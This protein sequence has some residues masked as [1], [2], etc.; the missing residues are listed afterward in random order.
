MSFNNS[1]D[2]DDDDYEP[3]LDSDWRGVRDSPRSLPLVPYKNQVGGHASFLRFS[4]KALCKPLNSKE[5]D[6]YEAVETMHPE[7]KSFIATYLGVVNVTYSTVPEDANIFGVAEG[8]PVVILEENKHILLDDHD[9]LDNRSSS[10]CDSV[11]N[12]SLYSRKLQAQVFKDALSP[13]SLRARFAQLRSAIGAMQRRHSFS[14]PA[15]RPACPIPMVDSDPRTLTPTKAKSP[16]SSEQRI[17]DPSTP[18]PPPSVVQETVDELRDHQ[19]QH[20]PTQH[21]KHHPRAEHDSGDGADVLSPIFQLSEEEEDRAP[22]AHPRKANLRP[23]SQGVRL[24]RSPSTPLRPSPAA[25]EHTVDLPPVLLTP[26]TPT[27][28]TA[29]TPVAHGRPPLHPHAH[30]LTAPATLIRTHTAPAGSASVTYNPWSLHLYHNAASKLGGAAAA[31]EA[32][33]GGRRRTDQF[34]L[35]QDLTS[36][37]RFPCILDLKMG[38]RQHGV[39]ASAEKR[40]S[41]EK[42]CEKSTSWTLGVRIC[43]MQVYKENT[44]AFTYLDKYVGRQINVANF[45]QSLLSFLDNGESYL[46]GYIPRML[47]KLRSLHAVVAKMPSYR[48]YASSLLILYDGAWAAD[49]SKN[50][51]EDTV[52]D[53]ADGL[54]DAFSVLLT[55]DEGEAV[56]LAAARDVDMKMIDFANCVS[57]AQVLRKLEEDSTTSVPSTPIEGPDANAGGIIRVPFPPTTRGP[58]NGYLLGL[59]TLI[60][61]FEDLHAHLADPARPRAHVKKSALTTAQKL[62]AAGGSAVASAD[63]AAFPTNLA[64][65]TGIAVPNVGQGG[66]L[67]PEPLLF[68]G[69][70]GAAAA[71]VSSLAKEDGN[72]L[73]NTISAG[74]TGPDDRTMAPATSFASGGGAGQDVRRRASGFMLVRRTPSLTPA[75]ARGGLGEM[76]V[77]SSA[78]VTTAVLGETGD[79][80]GDPSLQR[81]RTIDLQARQI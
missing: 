3:E 49:A 77:P 18:S 51:D 61:S 68:A 6:F 55:G 69:S 12:V 17:E 16:L 24:I 81:R 65:T 46:V 40:A 20:P 64:Q 50:G 75:S 59:R 62:H 23:S 28:S 53:D 76:T 66:I 52:E 27:R 30:G 29:V 38:R 39:L 31:D 10:S 34:L 57:N 67:F 60:H 22:D 48:F 43:G 13:Q 42:K 44:G 15:E 21:P 71:A 2:E 35:L 5:R 11:N 63:A 80:K 70:G 72:L 41:Q 78:S 4:D 33:A 36:G 26:A 25:L 1:D 32:A 37:L 56:D 45:Q 19:P 58:D 8:T 79:V 47:E 14:S 74:N 9:D 54:G 73:V 7:I